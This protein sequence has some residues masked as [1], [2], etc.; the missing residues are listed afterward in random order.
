ML[1]VPTPAMIQ[2]I[3]HEKIRAIL[4]ERGEAP[5][6]SGGEKL[7]ETLGLTSLDLAFLVADLEAEIGVDPFAK[8]VSITSVRSV[9]D[10]VKAYQLVFFPVAQP[11]KDEKMLTA[12][13]KRGQVRRSRRERS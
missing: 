9:N 1:A 12:A 13:M 7:N 8:L 2:S 5:S 3:V 6:L 11:N 10:L 4:A